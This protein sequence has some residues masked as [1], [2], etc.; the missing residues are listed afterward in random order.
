MT[1]TYQQLISEAIDRAQQIRDQRSGQYNTGVDIREYWT[2]GMSSIVHEISKKSKRMVSLIRA[3]A[4]PNALED[5]LLDIINYAAFGY[6]EL[7]ST[8]VGRHLEDP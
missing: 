2:F 4:P 7:R 8:N 6:A 3:N 1:A 5:S